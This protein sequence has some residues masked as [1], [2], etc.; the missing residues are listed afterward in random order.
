ML[1]KGA[2]KGILAHGKSEQEL[3]GRVVCLIMGVEALMLQRI[4]LRPTPDSRNAI[5]VTDY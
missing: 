2:A 3:R 5:V 4:H 1:Q